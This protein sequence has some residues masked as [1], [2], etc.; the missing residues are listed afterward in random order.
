MPFREAL[1]ATRGTMSMVDGT[2]VKPGPA[3]SCADTR[4]RS[5]PSALSLTS[6]RVA[7]IRQAFR[8]EWMTVTWMVVEGVVAL[9]AGL[10]AGSLTLMAFGLDSAIELASAGVLIW[11]LN[12][13]L[14]HG[15]GFSDAPNEPPAGSEPIRHVV[16]RKR[17]SF[18]FPTN[19]L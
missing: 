6:E 11:R 2:I 12:V 13:E 5:T 15:Q 19:G 4:C 7:L 3:E 16:E 10:A 14:R 8:L 18:T 1:Q 17:N 9:G